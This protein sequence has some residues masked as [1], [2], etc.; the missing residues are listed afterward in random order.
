M[1]LILLISCWFGNLDR[2]FFVSKEAAETS[3]R[4]GRGSRTIL[5]QRGFI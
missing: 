5:G 2:P 1:I 4:G 3:I